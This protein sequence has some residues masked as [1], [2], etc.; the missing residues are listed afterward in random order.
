[1]KGV[2]IS[3]ADA[4]QTQRRKV[5][6]SLYRKPGRFLRVFFCLFLEKNAFSNILRL[7][8][9]LAGWLI[10][11]FNKR[12]L[13]L[14]LSTR[15]I[16]LSS[17]SISTPSRR[18]PLPR[19]PRSGYLFLLLLL[20]LV[21]CSSPLLSRLPSR[22]ALLR[23]SLAPSP[24]LRCSTCSCSSCLPLSFV[25]SWS[26]FPSSS[27]SLLLLLLHLLLFLFFFYISWSLLFSF[28]SSLRG[29][30]LTF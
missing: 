14:C 26:S 28:F 25:S 8:E 12:H 2:R 30:N 7:T 6:V 10:I 16:I 24:R 29:N 27:S 23:N 18:F 22:R 1:M 21:S 3:N 5:C 20:P 13:S 15:F 4:S 19:L 17:L 9:R 11:G